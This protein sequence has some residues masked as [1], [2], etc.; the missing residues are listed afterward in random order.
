M[1]YRE[2]PSRE[3]QPTA[4]ISARDADDQSWWDRTIPALAQLLQSNDLNV[5]IVL[6]Y[7]KDL[8][9][10]TTNGST[11]PHSIISDEFYQVPIKMGTSCALSQSSFTSSGTLGGKIKLRNNK[12]LVELGLTNYHV[13]KDGLPNKGSLS[14]PFPPGSGKTYRNAT[15]PSNSDHEAFVKALNDSLIDVKKQYQ[16]QTQ[17]LEFLD[18]ND[19]SWTST[20]FAVKRYF[21]LQRLLEVQ[22]EESTGA[23]R[24]IGRIYAA[25]GFRTCKNGRMPVDIPESRRDW[26]LDWCLIQMDKSKPI[27]NELSNLPSSVGVLENVAVTRYCS[28]SRTPNYKVIKRG[29]TSGYTSG[30]ISAI[31]S[32]IR[33]AKGQ[34][35]RQ[36]GVGGRKVYRHNISQINP[37][38]RLQDTSQTDHISPTND[39]IP[40][41]EAW[42]DELVSVFPIISTKKTVLKFMEPGDS[43][44]LILL[45]RAKPTL[46]PIIGLGFSGNDVSGV[47]YMMPIDLI[48]KDIEAVTGGKVIEPRYA[49]E[50]KADK[51]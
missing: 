3:K 16:E 25:S 31:D 40:L 29:R 10:M 21:H 26:A 36:D 27:S 6:L 1:L 18:E 42:H 44:S 37:K 19:T 11:G 4:I 14:G 15:S 8:E 28:I 30:T 17:T 46:A 43:G 50:A 24:H 34:W 38:A 32:T 47:S 12:S 48:L 2:F 45:D 7:L 51:D 33:Y 49:G 5:D 13:M 23:S 39:Q 35:V 22:L 9:F 41:E 20:T